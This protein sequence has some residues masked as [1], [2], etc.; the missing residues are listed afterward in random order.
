MGDYLYIVIG[1]VWVV[2]SLYSNKQKQQKK[3]LMEEQRKSQPSSEPVQQRPRSII[4][5]LLDPEQEFLK[6][7]TV[8]F[9]EYMEPEEIKPPEIP[10]EVSYFNEYQSLEVVKDEVPAS[11]FEN[12][13]ATRGEMN[14]YD[15]REMSGSTHDEVPLI[16]DIAEEFDLRKAVIYSEILN[17]KYI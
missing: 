5:Q 16:E 12:Q 4:E 10:E 8:N 1:I 3:R 6:P 17:P 2:Y 15:K 13:Y 11:Y 7:S 14:Y 9:D